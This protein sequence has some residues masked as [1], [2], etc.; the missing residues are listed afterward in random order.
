MGA[1]FGL[2]RIQW[3]CGAII[4]NGSPEVAVTKVSVA[5]II[6]QIR[7]PLSGTDDGIVICDS[8]FEVSSCKFGVCFC[9]QI[10]ASP[11]RR[12]GLVPCRDRAFVW[13][14]LCAGQSQQKQ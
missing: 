12:S 5:K 4:Q 2:L 14:S 1:G 3:Y 7:A 9:E 10:I 8:A 11:F 13:R 6:K